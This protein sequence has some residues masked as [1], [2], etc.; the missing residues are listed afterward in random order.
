[1]PSTIVPESVGCR[2]VAL[3]DCCSAPSCRTFAT[4]VSGWA[5]G[6]AWVAGP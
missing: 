6:S 1:M 3:Q 4:L 5:G 2:L